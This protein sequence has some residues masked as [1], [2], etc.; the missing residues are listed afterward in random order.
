MRIEALE[1]KNYKTFKHLK[2][3]NLPEMVV[4]VGANG[5]G[6]TT[7]FD[8]FSFLQDA[9]AGTVSKAVNARG[10][11]KELVTRGCE[12]EAIEIIIKFRGSKNVLVTYELSIKPNPSN[13]FGVIVEKEV[14]K[15]RRGSKGKPWHFLDFKEGKGS[16]IKNENAY[17]A[18]NTE[19]AER[20]VRTLESA[21]TLALKGLGYLAEYPV[22]NEFRRL[23]ENWYISDFHMSAARESKKPTQEDNHLSKT[24]DNLA[25]V[26][27][28]L[29]E[30]QREI[31]DKILTIMAQR[32]PGIKNIK[33]KLTE[34][35]NLIL[36]FQDG[37]F[38]EPFLAK[39]VSD[40]TLKMFAYLLLLH[41][42]NGKQLLAIEEPENQLY[43]HLMRGLTEELEHYAHIQGQVFISTHSPEVLNAVNPKFVYLLSK[44]SG[45]TNLTKAMDDENV[46]S[47]VAG[48]DLLGYIWKQGLLVGLNE[49]N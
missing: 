32:V 27:L 8:V 14:L 6:K 49:V 36:L 1:L 38:K 10:R 47:L 20:E 13:S 43:P 31:F 22:V 39:A 5:T 35:G 15:Y 17:S 44:N 46:A 7:L 19:D 26:S 25:N 24:G 3:T 48:G 42:P 16:A 12:D 37:S 29:Y 18:T 11:Y 9:L 33:A 30:N 23:I 41:A 40:G 2:L 28:A 45:I 21:D 4:L 34:E